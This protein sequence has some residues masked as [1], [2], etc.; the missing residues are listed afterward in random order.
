MELIST[1]ENPQQLRSRER[2]NVVLAATKKILAEDGYS[3]L[4]LSAVCEIAGVKQ[5]SIYRY[6]PNKE[7]LLTSISDVFQE[8]FTIELAKIEDVAF[9]V[10]WR[11]VQKILVV[12]LAEWCEANFWVYSAQTAIR[13]SK[14]LHPRLDQL[15]SYFAA[16]YGHLLK[17]GGLG[18]RGEQEVVV[19]RTYTE[20]LA[21]FMYALEFANHSQP[22]IDAI[23]ERYTNLVVT[24]LAPMMQED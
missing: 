17:I 4:T 23:T 2:V 9:D 1:R 8:E 5:T 16:K 20:T 7:A 3:K 19:T 14:P 18:V 21:S 13:A 15:L 10:P 12:G 22:E 11:E 24:Y 6:W